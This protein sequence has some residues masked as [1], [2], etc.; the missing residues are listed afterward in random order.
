M[1]CL[2]AQVLF[3][4][5][6]ESDIGICITFLSFFTLF[7]LFIW[8]CSLVRLYAYKKGEGCMFVVLAPRSVYVSNLYFHIN[9][10]YWLFCNL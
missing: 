5:F 3:Y 10:S 7:I 8:I 9:A 2:Q 6:M 4:G 1:F